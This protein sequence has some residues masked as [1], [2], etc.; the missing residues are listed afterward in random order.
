[1]T[2]VS[3]LLPLPLLAAALA[4]AGP[5][6]PGPEPVRARRF[7]TAQACA[8]CHA[9]HPDATAMR[10]RDGG[11]IAPFDLWRGTMMANAARDPLW[12]AY[13]SAEVAATPSRRKEIEAK[14][15]R[16]H[17]P[18]AAAE[19]EARVG[20]GAL[21]MAVLDDEGDLGQLARDGVSCSLCHQ[22]RDVGLGQRGSWS[23]LF[24][25]GGPQ[26]IY[27]PHR[28]VRTRPMQ[29]H[30][31]YTPEYAPHVTR[32]AVC[33]TCHTLFT[34]AL[35]E[36]GDPTGHTLNEQGPYLEW[37]N[38]VFRTKADGA[39]APGPEARSC[40]DCHMPT[41]DEDGR[42][43]RTGIAR[44]PGG[45]DFPFVRPR[46]PYGLHLVVGANT[47]V[48]AILRDGP[49]RAAPRVAFDA[50]IHAARAM[51]QEH[52]ADVRIEDVTRR[53]GHLEVAVRVRNRTGHKFPTGLPLRRAWLRVRVRDADGRVR[54]AWG[55]HDE[56]GR[57]GGTDGDAFSFER[58]GGPVAPHRDR[59]AAPGHV[60]IY[61]SVMEDAAGAVTHTLL[62]GARYRKDNRLLPRGWR[63]DGPHAAVTAPAGAAATDDDFGA[64]GDRVLFVLPL[65]DSA[66][67]VEVDLL[68]QTLGARAA[69]ELFRTKTPEVAAFRKAYEKADRAPVTVASARA[70]VP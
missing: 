48:P 40:Q 54:L 46:A 27:G 68:Y 56:A 28:G 23:G 18:L 24:V 11:S 51:L 38:S 52:T 58:A 5:P 45:G 3:L 59:V 33:A 61:E 19:V 7:A 9:N 41:A 50:V 53:D 13:V 47:L 29:R 12:R 70:R 30:V 22:I 66:A 34:D 69:A 6:W 49:W 43:Y 42:A 37:R 25:A 57:I 14:C 1:V 31:G 26:R 10:D 16:C 15:L 20:R 4:V 35:D 21:S 64:G 67:T 8:V 44:W 32:S 65:V 55:D 60:P 39:E 36:N 2:R 63:R 17:A 62:R